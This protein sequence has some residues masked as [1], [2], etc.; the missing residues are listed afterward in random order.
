M[1]ALGGGGLNV[2]T[3]FCK[4]IIYPDG[5]STDIGQLS[6]KRIWNKHQLIICKSGDIIQM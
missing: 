5:T 4:W 3:K 1:N 6:I 2:N